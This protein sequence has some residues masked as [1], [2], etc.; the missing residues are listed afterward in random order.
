[1][2]MLEVVNE[3]GE[4]LREVDRETIHAEGLLHRE[5]HV[6]LVTPGGELIF[7][8]RAPDKDTFPDCLDASV[9]GHVDP[10]EEPIESAVREVGEEAGLR[11]NPADILEVQQ[12][13]SSSFDEV[14]NTTNNVLRTMYLLKL[15]QAVGGLQIEAGKAVGFEACS[16][17][18]LLTLDEV[19]KQRFVPSLVD[20]AGLERI[21]LLQTACNDWIF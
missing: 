2:E 17:D 13:A 5:I 14:T 12:Y 21:S 7:Q 8:H 16:F 3:N 1:M 4:V 10:G 20:Q 19:S 9:A 18:C 11:V 6:W 15:P